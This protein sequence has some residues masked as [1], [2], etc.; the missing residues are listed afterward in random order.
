[1]KQKL[2]R[3]KDY[4]PCCAHCAFGVT[5]EGDAEVLCRHN[6]VMRPDDSCASYVYDPL[7]R[8]P[9]RQ[10]FDVDYKPEEFTL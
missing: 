7:K 4:P 3:A 1:M 8:K 2:L 10:K 9:K 5:V 6:G